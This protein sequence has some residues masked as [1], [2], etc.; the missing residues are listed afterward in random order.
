MPVQRRELLR[1]GARAALLGAFGGLVACG[2]PLASDEAPVAEGAPDLGGRAPVQAV[3]P[4]RWAYGLLGPADGNGLRLPAGFTSRIVARSGQAVGTTGYVW[5]AWPDGAAVFPRPDG[6]WS[7][8]SNSE[9][10][11]GLG[12]VGM[13]RFASDGSIVAA[14]S[15]LTGTTLNCS[16]GATP[17]RTW[18]SCEEQERGRVFEIDPLGGAPPAE[19]P[20]LGRFIHEAAAVRPDGGVV[21]LTEDNPEGRFY[22]FRASP[23]GQVVTGVLEVAA[24]A[25]GGV[26]SWLAVPDPLAVVT[27]TR[28]QVSGSTPFAGGEGCWYTPGAV[29]FTTKLDGRLWRYDE[30]SSMLTV[31]YDA[32]AQGAPVLTG[33]DNLTAWPGGGLVV[34]E[35]GGDMQL[36]GLAPDGAVSPILQAVGQDTS[37][38]T[39]VGFDPSGQRLYVSS[40]RGFDGNGIIYEVT[41]PFPYRRALRVPSQ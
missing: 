29:V 3:E 37:E 35:D 15:L 34:C 13:L 2:R 38:L 41:G 31:L 32:T 10:P 1:A 40:Q 21:Y 25:A 33:V 19:R 39:G 9:V 5:H 7:Y 4:A 23:A 14:R 20:A 27:P 17:W 28:H 12:G 6:G 26:V 18:L 24:V 36:V 11:D 8:V 22:R 16:G 30:A